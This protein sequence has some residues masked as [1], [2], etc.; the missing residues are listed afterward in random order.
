MI[1]CVR[2]FEMKV[3]SERTDM[4]VV[5]GG[6]AGICAAITAS[7]EGARVC[8]IEKESFLGGKIGNSIFLCSGSVC[9]FLIA[10]TIITLLR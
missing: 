1:Q 7:R 10:T 8:L 3:T 6:I 9:H 4:V 2:E 5:G